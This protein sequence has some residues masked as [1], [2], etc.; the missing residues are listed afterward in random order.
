[1]QVRLGGGLAHGFLKSVLP[2]GGGVAAFHARGRR[3]AEVGGDELQVRALLA[4]LI[5][6][7][8]V[9]VARHE[10][11]GERDRQQPAQL[12]GV[13]AR[14]AHGRGE[15]R[16]QPGQAV[17]RRPLRALERGLDQARRGPGSALEL[18]EP[19][20][21]RGALFRPVVQVDQAEK[22]VPVQQRQAD[23]RLHLVAADES[24]VD[25]R[26]RVAGDQALPGHGQPHRR[27]V[28]VDA[29]L[30][31]D[32]ALALGGEIARELLV[33]VG[34][35]IEQ[36]LLRLAGGEGGVVGMGGFFVEEDGDDIGARGVLEVRDDA[37]EHRCKTGVG[38]N[39]R[40]NHFPTAII[41]SGAG[42]ER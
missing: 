21:V 38:F 14:V 34:Q 2:R 15:Q 10:Q 5:D 26:R 32:F 36:A 35:G 24:R 22:P 29:E 3:N 1:M 30:V 41:G 9:Q 12:F 8:P 27:T 13:G 20:V 42:V 37:A 6:R 11:V 39:R 40:A 28:L 16:G 19:V 33:H 17:Q 31:R 18:L 23:G 7:R 4:E 25:L